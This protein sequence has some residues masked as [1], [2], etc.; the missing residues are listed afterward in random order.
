MTRWGAGAYDPPMRGSLH[1][2]RWLAILLF[3][4]VAGGVAWAQHHERKR[5]ERAEILAMESE[6]RQAQLSDDIPEMDQLL[7][8]NFLG[9]TAAGQVVTKN[10]QLDRM[11]SRQIAISKLDMADTKIKI[12]D[13]LAVVSSLARLDGTS[14]GSPLHGYFRYTRVYQRSPGAGWKITNFE[15]T[16]VSSDTALL[17]VRASAPQASVAA[18]PVA[19]PSSLPAS[20]AEPSF[21]RPQS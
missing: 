5:V 3:L 14:N 13:N 12:S 1:Q 20:R 4:S 16:R 9:I 7:S 2:S 11:R 18:P 6:W 21:P 17:G 15:A 10:Q 19:S 8:D